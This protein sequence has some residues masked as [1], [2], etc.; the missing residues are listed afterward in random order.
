MFVKMAL[1]CS[2]IICPVK[3][4]RPKVCI[5]KFVKWCVCLYVWVCVKE[6]KSVR[7]RVSRH[8]CIRQG[9]GETFSNYNS[10]EP[11]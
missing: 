6:R 2:N 5:K 1:S 8:V 10:T 11:C 4:L 9:K 7:A 3:V